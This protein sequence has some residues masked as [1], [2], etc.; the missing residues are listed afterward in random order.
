[1]AL[2]ALLAT[3]LLPTGSARAAAPV[4]DGDPVGPVVGSVLGVITGI[5]G[6]LVPTGWL[7][8]S[9]TTTLPQVR[10]SIGADTMWA[11]GYTG[12]GVGVALIDTGVVAVPGLSQG[13]VV[14]GPDLSFESQSDALRHFDTY[15]HG[16]HMAGIIAGNEPPGL[17]VSTA[18]RAW[19]P[20][21][22]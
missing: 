12:K 18:S 19:L 2:A 4:A 20:A 3:A 16:T 22:G 8:D 14:N 1:M 7:F 21:P 6:D 11:R 13:N 10:Q 9:T 17:R 5:L 15:G